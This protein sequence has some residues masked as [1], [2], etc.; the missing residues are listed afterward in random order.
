[1]AIQIQNNLLEKAAATDTETYLAVFINAYLEAIDGS[2]NE[3]TMVLL[4]GW[5]HSLLAYHYFREEVLQ[6]GFIQLIQNGYGG[7]IFRNPFAKSLRIFGADELSKLI[8]KA[9]EIYD[10]NQ[11]ELEQEMSDDEFHALYEKYE[12]FEELEERFFDIENTCTEIIA[13]YVDN[14]LSDFA[15]IIQ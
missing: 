2:I 5:Q 12:A 13:S 11:N 1:M 10:L 3:K 4:N 9:R 15:D 6:G 8:Y 7:Y 14:H